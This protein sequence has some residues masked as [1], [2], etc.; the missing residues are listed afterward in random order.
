MRRCDPGAVGDFKAVSPWNKISILRETP[1]VVPNRRRSVPWTFRRSQAERAV[2]TVGGLSCKGEGLTGGTLA[3]RE[4]VENGEYVLDRFGRQHVRGP[5]H[6]SWYLHHTPICRL[7]EP[8]HGLF[9]VLCRRRADLGILSSHDS[10]I[11]RHESPGP[12]I[13]S[14]WSVS[15]G[16]TSSIVF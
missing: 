7:G 1:R 11:L 13:Y 5:R 14:C 8:E 10:Q 9:H 15:G 2:K 6:D 16:C 12:D 3:R 4:R